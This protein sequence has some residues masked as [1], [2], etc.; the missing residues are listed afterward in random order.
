M[1]IARVNKPPI[2]S[3]VDMEKFRPAPAP[4][5]SFTV[6][7]PNLATIYSGHYDRL[8]AVYAAAKSGD[9]LLLKLAVAH[10]DA[11]GWGE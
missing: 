2:F 8:Q 6:G 10:Q 4:V 11:H 7:G 9:P 3:A 5:F 1:A